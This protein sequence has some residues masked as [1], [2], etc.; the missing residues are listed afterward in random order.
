MIMYIIIYAYMNTRIELQRT[1]CYLPTSN[2]QTI[3]A[4]MRRKMRTALQLFSRH[5]DHVAK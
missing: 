1:L 2:S 5:R 3:T 4:R